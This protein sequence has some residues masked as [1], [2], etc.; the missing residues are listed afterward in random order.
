MGAR[1]GKVWLVGTGPGDVELLTLRAARVIE[2]ADVIAYDE[3]VSDEILALAPSHVER[4]AVGRRARGVR[5]H[6]AAIHP[7]VIERALAG[8]NIVRLKGGDPMIFGRGGEEG[9]AL[10]QAGIPFE[11]VPGI[12]A[13]LGAAASLGV[14]L[15]HRQISRQVT[16]VTAHGSSKE[17]L[18]TLTAEWPLHGTIVVYMGLGSLGEICACLIERGRSLETPCAVVSR[19]TTKHERSVVGTLEN[20][21]ERATAAAL[22]A[23]ALFIVGESVACLAEP[24]PQNRV[25]ALRIV[26]SSEASVHAML[27]EAL[28]RQRSNRRSAERSPQS[29]ASIA[30]APARSRS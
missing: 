27:P 7:I 21:V 26:H 15:T 29:R 14:P 18:D 9:Q 6:D 8:E 24:A 11:F 4:I 28:P 20:I 1:I 10:A 19:A 30:R 5:H 23:P 12:T 2:N 22:E 17:S 13:G 3:L 25:P 16:F